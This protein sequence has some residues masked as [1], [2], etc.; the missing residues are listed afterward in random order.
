MRQTKAMQAIKPIA[1]ANNLEFDGFTSKGHMRW[2][3]RPTGRVYISVKDT[4][5]YHTL[6]N[7]ERDMKRAVKEFTNGQYDHAH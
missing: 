4:T 5:S 3:H 2:K 7:T 6:K 1:T